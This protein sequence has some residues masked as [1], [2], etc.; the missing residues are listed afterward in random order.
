M[1]AATP[2]ASS[3]LVTS[4]RLMPSSASLLDDGVGL[5]VGALDG[6]SAVAM[7]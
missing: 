1:K 3:L 7:P 5:F 2:S 4:L 6:R